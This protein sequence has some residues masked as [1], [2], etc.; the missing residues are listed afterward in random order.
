VNEAIAGMEQQNIVIPSNNGVVKKLV[1]LLLII[2]VMLF[3]SWYYNSFM[4]AHVLP[5]VNATIYL[6]LNTSLPQSN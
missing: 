5:P 1:I 6:F 2:I 3:A 4:T